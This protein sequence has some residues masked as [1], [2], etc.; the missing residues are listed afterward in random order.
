MAPARQGLAMQVR[1]IVKRNAPFQTRDRG[2]KPRRRAPTRQ[3]LS[4][5]FVSVPPFSSIAHASVAAKVFGII[6]VIA[7]QQILV[8]SIARACL[9]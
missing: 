9:F 6:F 2:R 1:S 8:C 3:R 7:D 5:Q 4:I